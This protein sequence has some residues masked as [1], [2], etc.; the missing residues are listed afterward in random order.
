M[1]LL[2]PGFVAATETR[3]TVGRVRLEAD[4]RID[5]AIDMI[6]RAI[7]IGDSAPSKQP[8]VID[9]IVR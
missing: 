9:R 6:R 4:P 2:E 7:R 5:A 1:E 3:W 8:V